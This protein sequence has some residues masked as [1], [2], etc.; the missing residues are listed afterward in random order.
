MNLRDVGLLGRKYLIRSFYPLGLHKLYHYL[1]SYGKRNAVFVWIPKTAGTSI[2]TSLNQFHCPKFKNFLTAK[3]CFSQSGLVTFGHISYIDL[4]ENR[5][6][7][8]KFDET[9]F[10]FCFVRNPF[11]RSVSLF[12]YMK[13]AGRIHQN[14]SFKSFA[15]ILYDKAFPSVGLYNRNGL[16]QCNPQID[17]IKD[18]DRKIFVDFIGRI[19]NINEDFKKVCTHLG[20]NVELP[21]INKTI[22]KPYREYYDA[23]SRALITDAYRE[24]LETFGYAF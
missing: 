20:F 21:H 17:W 10:K 11:D 7:S 8:K 22:H 5:T 6:V 2:W 3:Y 23:E 18:R 13:N 14:L 15:H 1:K 19:E 16:S 4:K 12:H 24:D 9:A